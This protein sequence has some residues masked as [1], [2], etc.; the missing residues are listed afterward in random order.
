[1]AVQ[2]QAQFQQIGE[3]FCQHYYQTFDTNRPGLVSL[4][5]DQS[6]LTFEGEQFQGA[7]SIVQKLASLQFK[8]VRHQLVKAD[9]QPV[10]GSMNIIIFVT[11][12]LFVD[13]SPNP[14]KFAQIFHLAQ[15]NGNY[16]CLNDMFR[17]NI[18]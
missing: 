12:N 13:D 16:F 6:L 15:A 14:L 4:Y 9:C 18:G 3:Q 1:M 5:N 17:L 7:Q 2:M 8:T 10:P 11:G